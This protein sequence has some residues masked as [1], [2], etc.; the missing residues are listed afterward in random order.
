MYLIGNFTLL[1]IVLCTELS[2]SFK[3]IYNM[4]EYNNVRLATIE[5]VLSDKNFRNILFA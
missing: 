5:F 2:H 1:F 3:E 4:L